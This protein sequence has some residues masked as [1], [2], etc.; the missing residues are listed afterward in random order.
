MLLRTSIL[1]IMLAVLPLSGARYRFDYDLISDIRKTYAVF[2]KF[3]LFYHASASAY[4]TAQSL[5]NG[6]QAFRFAGIPDSSWRIRTHRRGSKLS[7]V[8]AAYTFDQAR[9][10]Y[11]RRIATFRAEAPFYAGMIEE[12]DKRP[13]RILPTTGSSI[14]F[15]RNQ[16]GSYNSYGY[17]L[18]MV[19][20]PG[21]KPYNDSFNVY[22]LLLES[23][24]MLSHK[25]LPGAGLSSLPA[26]GTSWQSPWINYGKNFSDI[27]LLADHKGASHYKYAQPH[28]FLMRYRVTS[29]SGGTIT[30]TGSAAPQVAIGMDMKIRTITRVLAWRQSD[31]MLLRD[32]LSLKALNEDN[33][34][35]TI[36][37]S[38]RLLQ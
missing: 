17:A 4:F 19:E 5:G 24:K 33:L 30:V 28:S 25:A 6:N 26:D 18:Q 14:R 23:V 11:N 22:K 37:A 9:A 20:P 31:G 7:V 16:D 34:G 27:S 8:T 15:N 13:F 1:C 29:R 12:T 2:Y 38:L 21:V 36:R 35:W 32:E 3:R 10:A